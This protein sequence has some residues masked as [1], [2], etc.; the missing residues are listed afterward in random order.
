LRP[1]LH[2]SRPKTAIWRANLLLEIEIEAI[3]VAA[4]GGDIRRRGLTAE[5]FSDCL[6]IVAHIGV[7]Q[8]REKPKHARTMRDFIPREIELEILGTG[9]SEVCIEIDTIRHLGH[10]Q[11]AE[12]R[13]KPMIV[14]LDDDAIRVA[15]RV[16]SVV[17]RSVIIDRPV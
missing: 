7:V 6:L 5:I 3:L 17:V 11:F 9:A 12:S 10:Q 1:S 16:R 4:R 2:P 8:V 13:R 15:A 14:V